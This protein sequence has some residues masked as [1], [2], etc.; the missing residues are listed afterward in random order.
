MPDATATTEPK[1]APPDVKIDDV[2]PAL[3][4]LTITISS[5]AISQKLEESIGALAREATLPGFRRGKVPRKLLEKRFG[6][7]VQDET[8]NKL[9][10]DAY[11]QAIEHHGIQPVGE[12]E[13]T[14]PP[15][16]LK[17]EPGKPLTFAVDVEV[18]PV[19]ELPDL[20]GIEIKKPLL[21]ITPEHIEDRLR[22]QML[23][24]G[25][26]VK[27]EEGFKE[28]DRLAGH[29]KVTKKG[30]SEPF[31]QQDDAILV[32]PPEADGG[33]GPVLGVMVDG[34]AGLIASKR[35]GETLV[36]ETVGP[37]GHERE[38]IRGAPLEITF[39]ITAA[40]RIEPAPIERLI[41]IFGAGTEESLRDQMRIALQHQ[42]DQEQATA[43]REQVH[44]HLLENVALELPE[45]LS[46]AQAGRVLEGRRLELLERGVPP[47]DVERILAEIRGR[48]EAE[49]RDQLKLFF[50]LHKLAV[51]SEVTVSEQEVNGRIAAIAVQNGQRPDVLK[52]ELS[53]AGRLGE[54]ARM[55]RDQKA[56]DNVVA[57]AKVQ[58]VD[59]QEWNRMIEERQ[60]AAAGPADAK[61]AASGA[62]AAP[63][64][65][66]SGAKTRKGK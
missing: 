21:E 56:A 36:I 52:T 31:F 43:M 28:G 55:V 16:S 15:E 57:Q 30:E 38:D 46:A 53:R 9:I 24:M 8:R 10:A 14:Q 25:S 61:K 42:R 6:T 22:R 7:S 64:K 18:V 51:Q 17:I 62:K 66:K 39:R 54:V 20:T 40:R 65:G 50:L 59:A 48:S 5:E 49:A 19:F 2:G 35:V 27:I 12:P 37:E 58:E 34:L 60:A 4:R 1:Q 33:R 63:R 41:E 3:K 23:R 11:A 29:V 26:I 32:C 45:K 44:R 47:D 13:P